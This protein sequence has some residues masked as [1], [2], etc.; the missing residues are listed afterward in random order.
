M[1]K[2]RLDDLQI[3]LQDLPH[4]SRILA[5]AET[6]PLT[7]RH[8]QGALGRAQREYRPLTHPQ[9]ARVSIRA[10]RSSNSG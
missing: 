8:S 7:A 4:G 5:A 10:P 2:S 3:S 9:S 1:S 6:G